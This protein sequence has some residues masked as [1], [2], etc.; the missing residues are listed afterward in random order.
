MKFSVCLSTGFEGVM[1][2]IPFAGPEDFIEQGKLCERLGYDSVWGNDHITTQDYVRNLFPDT[3][4]NFYEPLIVLAAIGAVTTKLKLGTALCVLPMRDPVYLAK[5]VISLDQM[6]NGRFIL[7]VGLGA[8]REEFQA[9]AGSRAAKSRRGDMMDEG[10]KSLEMLFTEKSA[11]F[12]GKY[13]SF[14]DVEM[15]PKSRKQPFPLYIGGHNLEALE[16]AARYGQGWLPGWRPLNELAERIVKLK[17][18]AA[19]LGRDPADIEIAPQ[20]SVTIDKTMEAAEKRYMES[21]LVAHRVS[22][23]YTGR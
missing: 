21:G 14:K 18:R 9:W 11:S 12:E 13:Y 19:E 20:F 8:Y 7:A 5:Q 23:A 16:R 17:E 22:L 15:F 4:P 1:Y 10:L 2:P 6:S 3:P